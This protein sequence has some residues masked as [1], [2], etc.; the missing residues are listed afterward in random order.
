MKS[1]NSAVPS[2]FEK[3]M[4]STDLNNRKHLPITTEAPDSSI[5]QKPEAISLSEL[6]YTPI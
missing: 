1:E 6:N 3:I 4:Y 5:H 2:N